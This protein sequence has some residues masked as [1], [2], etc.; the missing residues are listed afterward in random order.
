MIIVIAKLVS[1][2]I[3][4]LGF[5]VG[6]SYVIARTSDGKTNSN[7]FNK[8]EYVKNNRAVFGINDRECSD[9]KE[10]YTVSPEKLGF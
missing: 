2:V 1:A 7:K 9:V 4:G 8:N 10:V 5:Y 6:A 3:V